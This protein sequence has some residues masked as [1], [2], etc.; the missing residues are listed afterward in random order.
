MIHKYFNRIVIVGA[1]T[2]AAILPVAAQNRNAAT[3]APAAGSAKVTSDW[4]DMYSADPAK[5][6]Y[7]VDVLG[8]IAEAGDKVI[9]TRAFDLLSSLKGD[10][11]ASIRSSVA[12]S[13]GRAGLAHDYL[14]IPACGALE[15]MKGDADI[16]VR[17]A[18]LVNRSRL[19]GQS[20]TE[21]E[22]L[23]SDLL[24][25]SRD[26]DLYTRNIAAMGLGNAGAKYVSIRGRAAERLA[27]MQDD[28]TPTVKDTVKRA[29]AQID[30]A[31]AAAQKVPTL[32]P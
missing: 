22:G 7:V 18:A 30:A 2:V 14:A 27:A 15:S 12:N 26:A 8:T 20:A 6:A 5:R 10:P 29:L 1:L 28:S 19:P 17:G 16:H 3:T 13:L 25:A 23:F 9:A 31:K 11:Q 4:S 21:V 32:K 24:T